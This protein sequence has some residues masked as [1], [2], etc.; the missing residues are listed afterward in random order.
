M[1]SKNG[2]GKRP[3]SANHAK[4][5]A[6]RCQPRPFTRRARIDVTHRANRNVGEVISAELERVVSACSDDRHFL[7]V[8]FEVAK[9]TVTMLEEA[10][11]QVR[12]MVEVAREVVDGE[13]NFEEATDVLLWPPDIT[14]LLSPIDTLGAFICE[15]HSGNEVSLPS[16]PDMSSLAKHFA[17]QL[18]IERRRDDGGG[19]V[20]LAHRVLDAID[21]AMGSVAAE[22]PRQSA[23]ASA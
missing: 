7:S 13:R 6:P 14:G 11:E 22:R 20:Y 5:E 15:R 18:F 4:A 12:D 9:E 8:L 23:A 21:R 2:K 3:S 16:Y 17:E 10:A 1:P 19:E